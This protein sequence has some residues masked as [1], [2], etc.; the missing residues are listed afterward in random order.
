MGRRG[1]ETAPEAALR[2]R[3]IRGDRFDRLGPMVAIAV[4]K[5]HQYTLEVGQLEDPVIEVESGRGAATST[6]A[7][8]APARLARPW[9]T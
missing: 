3:V 2:Q 4:G 8:D 1:A 6:P 5:I 7:I 9:I